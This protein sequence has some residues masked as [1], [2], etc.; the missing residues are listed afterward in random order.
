MECPDSCSRSGD[1]ER[2]WPG[3]CLNGFW[4]WVFIFC[5][6]FQFRV[7]Q[8]RYSQN[9][10]QTVQERRGKGINEQLSLA[11]LF[12]SMAPNQ[13]PIVDCLV[14]PPLLNLFREPYFGVGKGV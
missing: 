6:F 7:F 4:S 3:N 14:R 1:V 12:P 5:L 2:L 10:K 9:S 11:A 13:E 8:R